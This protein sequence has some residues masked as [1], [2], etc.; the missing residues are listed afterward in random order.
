M[1][2]YHVGYWSWRFEIAVVGGHRLAHQ[3]RRRHLVYNRIVL[4]V[5]DE[6]R[7]VPELLEHSCRQVLVIFVVADNTATAQGNKFTRVAAL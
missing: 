5:G 6:K 2:Y 3:F 4:D 1:D 7:S